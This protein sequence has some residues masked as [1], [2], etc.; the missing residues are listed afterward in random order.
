MRSWITTGP[1]A[2]FA[3]VTLFGTLIHKTRRAYLF[4]SEDQGEEW[5]PKSIASWDGEAK[6]MT[7][8][9]WFA[10]RRKLI[11]EPPDDN[12]PAWE[13]ILQGTPTFVA[14]KVVVKHRK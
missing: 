9:R 5:I 13:V 4:A 14:K 7:M 12:D 2:Q 11:S 8:P 3:P 10:R 1:L 6:T